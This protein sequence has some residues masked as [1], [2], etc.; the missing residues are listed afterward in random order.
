[1]FKISRKFIIAVAC[2]Y[3]VVEVTNIWWLSSD[4]RNTN[5][6]HRQSPS[7]KNIPQY[8]SYYALLKETKALD[9]NISTIKTSS[10]EEQNSLCSTEIAMFYNLIKQST[11]QMG[12]PNHIQ[13]Y[14]AH[15]C[16]CV[17]YLHIRTDPRGLAYQQFFY[18]HTFP[19]EVCF[20]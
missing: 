5:N 15:T 13:S 16:L 7:I 11:L 8:P 4:S 2:L 14:I 20:V 18:L 6:E 9:N 1:M 3:F 19:S 12:Y 17:S 10:L